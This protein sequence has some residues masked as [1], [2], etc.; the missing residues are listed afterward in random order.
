MFSI[1][2]YGVTIFLIFVV[3]PFLH[4]FN[5]ESES[6]SR[7]RL[8]KAII[9]TFGF[10]MLMTILLLFGAFM[11]PSFP[12]PSLIINKIIHLA[13][14]T[15][16]QNALIMVLTI[17]TGAGFLNVTFYTASGLIAWPIGL[18]MGTSS[19]ATRVND[20]NDREVLLRMRINNLEEKAR[21]SRL[22]PTEREQLIEAQNDLRELEREEAALSGYSG[23]WTYKFRKAIRPVQIVTG[24]VF[25]ALSILLMSSMISV[26]VDRVLHGAG[27]K[28]GY[29]LLEPMIFN[30][31]D[32]VYTKLQDLIVIGPMPLLIVTCFLVVATISGIRN[33]GLW[34]LFVRLHRIKVG[35]TQPQALLYLC[36]TLMLAALAFNL[37]LYSMTTQYVTF[38]NQNYRQEVNGTMVVKPCSLKDFSEDCILTRSSVLLMRMMS[39]VWIV[40]AIFYWWSWV[41]VGIGAIALVACLV[42]GR[43]EASHGII[44]D[45][46]EFED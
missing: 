8:H 16:A 46:D 7:D 1:A 40:G 12:D 44:S 25:G 6:N 28:Q 32:Y 24:C 13:Q 11:K 9:Y 23:S 5:E 21:A 33:L 45:Q 38:G 19:L 31:L 17:I 3:I 20:V 15:K 27:P 4:F 22:T 30:P 2:L 36:V 34:L 18:I 43:R 39:Q 14:T 37:T 41:F 10:A 29:V 35:R 42:R 26:N